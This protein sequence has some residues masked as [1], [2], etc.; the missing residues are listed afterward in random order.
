MLIPRLRNDSSELPRLALSLGTLA[1]VGF[2]LVLFAQLSAMQLAPRSSY[3]LSNLLGEPGRNVL[4]LTL[5][6]GVLIPAS[7]GLLLFWRTGSRAIEIL[8]YWATVLSPLFDRVRSARVVPSPGGGDQTALLLGDAVRLRPRAAGI[9]SR[10]V[11]SVEHAKSRRSG[12]TARALPTAVCALSR[13]RLSAP[14]AWALV[15]L[16]A[17]ATRFFSVTTRSPTIA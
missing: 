7:V 6:I 15:L 9:G 13:L 4:L 14:V 16:A 1:A 11:A 8:E 2:S 3:T 17:A 10:V 12:Q 5:G